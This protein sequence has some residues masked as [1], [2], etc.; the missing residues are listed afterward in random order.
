[1]VA[2][3]KSPSGEEF[4]YKEPCVRSWEGNRELRKRAISKEMLMVDKDSTDSTIIAPSLPN[5]KLNYPI[6]KGFTAHM[7]AAGIICTNRIRMIQEPVIAFYELM[8]ADTGTAEVKALCYG[9][10]YHIKRMLHVVKRKWS[11]W[12]MP[13]VTRLFVYPEIL[14]RFLVVESL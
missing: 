8:Q 10:A 2:K 4:S 3:S 1:M 12:E 7:A 6:L 5:L 11:R 13:R 14:F 9:T